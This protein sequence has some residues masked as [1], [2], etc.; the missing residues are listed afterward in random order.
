MKVIVILLCALAAITLPAPAQTPLVKEAQKAYLAGDMETAKQKFEIVLAEDP[1]NAAA[2]NYLK[3]IA[4]SEARAGSGAKLQKQLQSLILPQV[5]LREATLGATLDYLRQQAGK[6]SGGK[7][8][9][10]FVLN[11]EVSASTPITLHLTNVP[12]T[13]VLRYVG[14]L[15]KVEFVIE[16]YAI[17]VKRK[18]APAAQ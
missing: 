8:Q 10:S 6:V 3:M 13:E 12:F 5:D 18:S 4:I 2:R 1:H 17:T 14:E 9:T 16:Q 11:P 15:A 7:I